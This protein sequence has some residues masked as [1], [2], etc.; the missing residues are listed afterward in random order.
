MSLIIWSKE[1]DVF[2]CL[3]LDFYYLFTHLF[4]PEIKKSFFRS[5]STR[6]RHHITFPQ[7]SS[8]PETH[9][10]AFPVSSKAPFLLKPL[11]L[12]QTQLYQDEKHLLC[13]RS[14]FGAIN[15]SSPSCAVRGG[16][17]SGRKRMWAG[18]EIKSPLY[19]CRGGRKSCN[20]N[21]GRFGLQLLSSVC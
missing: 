10:K 21:I 15:A 9:Y 1:D 2:M 12:L 13:L 6:V 14:F 5:L 4:H 7:S 20:Y 16:G 3:C 11:K 8:A 18:S 17:E 19:V